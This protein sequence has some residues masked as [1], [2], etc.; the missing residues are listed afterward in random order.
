LFLSRVYKRLRASAALAKNKKISNR[1][2]K[3]WLKE[4]NNIILKKEKSPDRIKFTLPNKSLSHVVR[5]N[6]CLSIALAFRPGIKVHQ[7]IVP[8]YY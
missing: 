5:H 4:K 8:R 1:A 7:I 2:F 6:D 3:I